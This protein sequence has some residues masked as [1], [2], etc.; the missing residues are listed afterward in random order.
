[1][2][3]RFSRF[4]IRY[5]VLIVDVLKKTTAKATLCLP[6][7][8][9]YQLK[10]RQKLLALARTGFYRYGQDNQWPGLFCV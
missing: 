3:N 8:V 5:E 2:M 6:G 9:G 4:P 1:M 7:F 10:C